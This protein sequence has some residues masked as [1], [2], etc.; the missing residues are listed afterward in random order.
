MDVNNIEKL[1]SS[2]YS[3]NTIFH[4]NKIFNKNIKIIK[5]YFNEIIKEDWFIYKAPMKYI[6]RTNILPR[7]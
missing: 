4:K 1:I 7:K 2:I 6:K 3:D 5:D